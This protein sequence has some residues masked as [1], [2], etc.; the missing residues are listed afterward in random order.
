MSDIGWVAL[1]PA[2][3]LDADV[4]L[5][6][7]PICFLPAL[8]YNLPYKRPLMRPLPHLPPYFNLMEDRASGDPTI[9][10]KFLFDL[11]TDPDVAL[12][13]VL[14]ALTPYSNF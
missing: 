4:Y 3:F 9:Y 10:I 6:M 5:V 14:W 7:C 13:T 11:S 12:L 8:S 2:P 1:G